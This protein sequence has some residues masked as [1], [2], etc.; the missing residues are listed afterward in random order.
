M[1]GS[2]ARDGT[3]HRH[4]FQIPDSS[5]GADRPNLSLRRYDE[6]ICIE[7]STCGMTARLGRGKMDEIEREK[8]RE[9][10]DASET[11]YCSLSRRRIPPQHPYIMPRTAADTVL[12]CTGNFL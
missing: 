8:A 1:V 7:E 3:I 5:P 11:L 10:R 9:P 6:I 4:T 12:G 2:F